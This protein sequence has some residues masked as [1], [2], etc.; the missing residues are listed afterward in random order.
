M[1]ASAD[2][3]LPPAKRR[4]VVSCESSTSKAVTEAVTDLLPRDCLLHVFKLLRKP[5]D[6]SSASLVCRAWHLLIASSITRFTL[7]KPQPK[8]R[9]QE[10]YFRFPNLIALELRHSLELTQDLATRLADWCPNLQSVHLLDGSWVSDCALAIL[11][12]GCPTLRILHLKYSNG[13]SHAG[14]NSI[15]ALGAQLEDL[16]LPPIGSIDDIFLAAL[17]HSAP[18]LRSLS[19]SGDYLSLNSLVQGYSFH[20]AGQ[21]WPS[22]RAL[23]V[24]FGEITDLGLELIATEFSQLEIFGCAHLRKATSD[25]FLHLVTSLQS[26]RHL[27]MMD[28]GEPWLT[29]VGCARSSSLCKIQLDPASDVTARSLSALANGCQNLQEIE[30]AASNFDY[31]M[32]FTAIEARFI[33]VRRVAMSILC[34]PNASL[35]ALLRCWPNILHLHISG[36]S[37]HGLAE[38]LQQLPKVWVFVS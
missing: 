26:L 11:L 12:T 14:L 27:N 2:D 9:L 38:L 18:R 23:D 37:E 25:G 7:T 32:D 28:N 29:A 8:P 24:S 3:E 17:C 16:V 31:A 6:F 21:H 30:L 35:I 13:L 10:S 5:K 4:F 22:L 19:F 34:I 1:C 20:N 36:W 15:L 33:K